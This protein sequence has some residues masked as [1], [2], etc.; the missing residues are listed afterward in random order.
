MIRRS[1]HRYRL[2]TGWT[3]SPTESKAEQQDWLRA[4]VPG[5]VLAALIDNKKL[6]DPNIG[7]ESELLPDV[8][9][10]PGLYSRFWQNQFTLPSDSLQSGQQVWLVLNGI[11][12]SFQASLNGHWLTQCP[13]FEKG[14]FRRHLF[15][16]TGT[17]QPAEQ[18]QKLMLFIKSPD[19][20]GC[21]DKG[22]QGGDHFIARNVTVEFTAGWDWIV[23]MCDR[24]TGIWDTVEVQVTGP[25]RVQD[26]HVITGAAEAGVPLQ[27]MAAIEARVQRPALWWPIHLGSQALYELRVEVH[28]P[29]HGISDAAVQRFGVRSIGSVIDPQSGGHTFFVNGCKVFIRGG[30]Y[31]CADAMMRATDERLHQEVAMHADMG[32]NMIRLWGGCG[33]TRF[34]FLD[35]CD[36][37]GLLVWWEFWVTGDC[38]GRGATADS[39]VSD[40][41]WPDDHRLWLQCAADTITRVRNHP[42]IALWCGGNE[43]VPCPPLD[44]GLRRMLPRSPVH[45]SSLD[46]T[47]LDESAAH[48]VPGVLD[49]SRAYVPGSLWE[50]FGEG[51]GAFSDGPY[52]IQNPEDFFRP[53]YYQYAFNPEVGSVGVPVLETL[54][55]IFDREDQRQ[56][57]S[58]M[59]LPDGDFEE[60]PNHAWEVHTHMAYGSPGSVPNQI[61]QYGVPADLQQYADQA[62]IA[63]F[64]QYRALLE[65]WASQMWHPYTGVLIWKT[66]NPWAGL[67]G[68]LYDWLLDQT[69]GFF[70]AKAACEPLHVQLNLAT[71]QVEL[72][73]T[74]RQAATNLT[75]QATVVSLPGLSGSS[76]M[77]GSWQQSGCTILPMTCSSVQPVDIPWAACGPLAF[78]FL[79]LRDSAGQIVS[80]N[81]YW[82]KASSAPHL[83]CLRPWCTT[84]LASLYISDLSIEELQQKTTARFS[85]GNA[86]SGH[87]AFWVRLKVMKKAS[88]ETAGRLDQADLR[89]LPVYYS[90]NYVTLAPG[91]KLPV[92]VSFDSQAPAVLTAQG[93]NTDELSLEVAS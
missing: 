64:V 46:S 30:N 25:I 9:H 43:Q 3:I 38:Q 74:S 67:R 65:G 8:Y 60:Q 63:N 89:V 75:V 79:A 86:H 92:V 34:P 53:G 56:P 54:Q 24:S 81:V 62:Q 88:S 32:L 44:A 33:A 58:L 29:A 61:C 45:S 69:A 91:E 19:Y 90:T 55:R 10:S 76:W 31:I 72:V 16:V 6:S 68:Q 20:P 66:Q 5:S 70:G 87:L 80:R 52:G 21:V 17:I 27:G 93:W 82:L 77:Q 2:N 22:G 28:I 1:H 73:N 23:P 35:T 13:S 47:A 41:N 42:C 40:Q 12:Y 14:M 49:A 7:T 15:N 18:L 78:V 84:H 57:P 51:S 37:L 4:Q 36:Q 50:G 11:N 59:Q 48:D 85:L 26:V 39:P 71:L 83:H